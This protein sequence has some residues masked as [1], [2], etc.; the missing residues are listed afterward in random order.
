MRLACI[1][2]RSP[3]QVSPSPKILLLLT[4]SFRAQQP[5]QPA[6]FGLLGH[7]LSRASPIPEAASP[8]TPHP[9]TLPAAP[10]PPFPTALQQPPSSSAVSSGDSASLPPRV[11]HRPIRA[12]RGDIKIS[13]TTAGRRHRPQR[14]RCSFLRG[15]RPPSDPG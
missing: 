1:L 13:L 5:F 9:Q 6:G 11:P 4:P 15:P 2:L 7:A 8:T 3:A 14:R 10:R 12:A